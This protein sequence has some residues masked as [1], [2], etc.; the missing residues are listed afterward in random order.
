MKISTSI[1]AALCLFTCCALS[2]DNLY[3]DNQM[4]GDSN[5]GLSQAPGSAGKGPFRSIA[6]A[7]AKAKPGDTVNLAPGRVFREGVKI[8]SFKATKESPLIIDGHGSSIYGA[9]PL[10]E[11][12]WSK[13]GDGLFKSESL[14]AALKRNPEFGMF[15]NGEALLYR[16]F[17]IFD[18]KLQRMGRS[19]KGYCAPFKKTE[20]LLPGEWTFDAASSTFFIKTDGRS[21]G[22]SKI[23]MPA[24][25]SGVAISGKGNA[26]I[27]IRN[28]AVRRVL[29]DGFNIH[30]SGVALRF[31]N[32]AAIECGDDGVSAHE[33]CEFEID[34]Y[35]SY[36]NM[37]GVCN[38]GNTVCR[39]SRM[40]LEGDVARELFSLEAASFDVRDSF[41]DA[42]ISEYAITAASNQ[43]KG[44]FSKI[45]ME[46]VL[47][48]NLSKSGHSVSSAPSCALNFKSCAF[49][50][51]NLKLAGESTIE[52][53]LF[54]GEGAS[55]VELLRSAKLQ[56]KGNIYAVGKF[57]FGGKDYTPATFK[58]YQEASGQDALSVLLGPISNAEREAFLKG[59]PQTE[60]FKIPSAAFRE[61]M[62]S[63][64]PSVRP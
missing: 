59:G 7:I 41:I 31:E 43:K 26:N 40:R 58:N 35:A 28:L 21:L 49:V 42:S 62:N 33:D 24:I 61:M 34:G 37:T 13:Q 48:V 53:T 18:G 60:P 64:P 63:L 11:K 45:G 2:A 1:A 23:E 54:L 57:R 36:G 16:V 38:I 5:D 51:V 19:C 47:V 52:K 55:Y 20:A 8:K 32:I 12:L 4:G 30:D 10:D 9:T 14:F 39:L 25:L 6:A 3:V 29:N 46:N 22:E 17:F 56:A 44:L 50:G 15:N 27:V